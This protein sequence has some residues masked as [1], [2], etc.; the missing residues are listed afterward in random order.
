ML[1]NADQTPCLFWAAA[2]RTCTVG[3]HG[4]KKSTNVLVALGVEDGKL[5]FGGNVAGPAREG[6]D[7]ALVYGR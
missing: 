7:M 1:R 6:C 4:V 5:A 2:G 3:Q